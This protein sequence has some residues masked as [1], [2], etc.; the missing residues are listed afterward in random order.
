MGGHRRGL[1]GPVGAWGD[2]RVWDGNWMGGSY[3]WYFGSCGCVSTMFRL[4]K[5]TL[6]L[7]VVSHSVEHQTHLGGI[8]HPVLV[9]LL[10]GCHVSND[11]R[12]R[13]FTWG[14]VS[15][16]RCTH[17]LPPRWTTTTVVIQRDE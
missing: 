13:Q 2:I 1:Y 5:Q 17:H 9:G 4:L 3:G 16:H 10:G 8:V 7:T 12:R 15:A 11:E 6:P 14:H